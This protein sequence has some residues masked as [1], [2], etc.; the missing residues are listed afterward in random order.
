MSLINA[1]MLMSERYL[2]VCVSLEAQAQRHRGDT[3][4]GST[5]EVKELKYSSST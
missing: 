2:T 5:S 4:T 3:F 1:L